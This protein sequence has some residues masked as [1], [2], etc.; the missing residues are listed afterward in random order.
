MIL[1]IIHYCWFENKLLFS[2]YKNYV[3]KEETSDLYS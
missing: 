1:K 2:Q 3:D